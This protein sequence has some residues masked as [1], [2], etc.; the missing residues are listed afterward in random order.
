MTANTGRTTYRCGL[1]SMA[2]VLLVGALTP[3]AG[4]G[5]SDPV[6]SI[7]VKNYAETHST[8]YSVNYA[9]GTWDPGMRTYSWSLASPVELWD[10]GTLL[11]TLLDASVVIQEAPTP[12]IDLDIEVLAGPDHAKFYVDSALLDFPT[13]PADMAEGE[14]S[15][16]VTVW[17]DGGSGF[18]LQGLGWTGAGACQSYYNGANPNG[19]LFS[20]LIGVVSGANWAMVPDDYAGPIGT[21]I[22]DMRAHDA[23]VLTQLDRARVESVFGVVPEPAGFLLLALGGALMG[24]RR[25]GS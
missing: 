17:D 8:M 1:A 18:M 4:A 10:D 15:A 20:H 5:I 14:F 16:V 7:E 22:H 25:R 12:L 11:G 6:F 24:G 19:T 9:D 2:L 13:I 23:F 21:E 3:H